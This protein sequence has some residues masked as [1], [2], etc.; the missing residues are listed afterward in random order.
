[1]LARRWREEAVA[2]RLRG[3]DKQASVLE[4][5]AAELDEH[6]RL[7]SLAALTLE[8]AVEESGYSYTA[9][10]KMVA[11]GRLA[12]V[13]RRHRPRVRRGDLPKKGKRPSP[14]QSEPDLAAQV[15]A[16]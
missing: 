16:S 9:I 13:G 2:L 8:E 11:T 5:C 3:A 14:V 15:L 6:A 7:V 4:S 1:M 12:N 10:Q